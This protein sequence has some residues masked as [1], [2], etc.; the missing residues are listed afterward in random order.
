MNEREFL[1]DLRG[2][3]GKIACL[4]DSDI[5]TPKGKSIFNCLSGVADYI[6]GRISALEEGR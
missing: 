6:N 1:E 4:V 5:K 3:L 2:K